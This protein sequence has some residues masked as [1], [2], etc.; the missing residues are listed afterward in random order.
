LSIARSR[1]A[2]R[3]RALGQL[4]V[5]AAIVASMNYVP[6]AAF[7]AL[8]CVAIGVPLEFVVGF[9]GALGIFSGMLAWWLLVF[10]GAMTYSVFVFPWDES[11]HG[12][13]GNGARGP[14]KRATLNA[15]SGR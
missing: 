2:E 8:L 10:V 14:A 6:A 15:N 11:S 7:V 13:G 12:I 5:M 9:G 1:Q 3:I 4:I